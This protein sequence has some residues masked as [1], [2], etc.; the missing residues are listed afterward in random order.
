[1][2]AKDPSEANSF[3]DRLRSPI[4]MT[5]IRS[6]ATIAIGLVLTV[7]LPTRFTEE[8][9]AQ[10]MA[11]MVAPFEG[12]F[13]E[14]ARHHLLSKPDERPKIAIVTI[15]QESLGPPPNG[16]G[17]GSWPAPYR[18]YSALL[19]AL[20]KA[21]A[22]AVFLDV[23]LSHA[24]QR[25]EFDTLKTSI[26]AF[27]AESRASAEHPHVFLAARRDCNNAL[28][29]NPDIDPLTSVTKVG[30]EFSPNEVDR[31]AWTYPLAYM[32]SFAKEHEDQ[33]GQT[34][35]PVSTD[36]GSDSKA[37][38]NCTAE[39][40]QSENELPRSAA[41]A[42]YLALPHAKPLDLKD[43]KARTMSV[44]WGL[45]TASDGL[46]WREENDE[47]KHARSE[48]AL[49]H[50]DA[51]EPDDDMYCTSSDHMPVLLLRAEA[52]AWYRSLSRPLC[53]FH[54]TYPASIILPMNPTD[55]AKLLDDR[56]VL[57]GTSLRYSNDIVTSPL[58]DRIPGVFLHAMAL[59]NLIQ[60]HGEPPKNWEP[61]SSLVEGWHN[62]YLKLAVLGVISIFL[63]R[64]AKDA[65]RKHTRSTYLGRHE[66]REKLF[67]RQWAVAK[68]K[69]AAFNFLWYFISGLILIVFAIVFLLIGRHGMGLPYLIV[70]H[71]IAC[72]LAVEWLEW[73]EKFADWLMDW[74]EEKKHENPAT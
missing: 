18:Y 70:A 27:N 36:T 7:L 14:L 16:F 60:Y 69:V 66:R 29:I 42:M 37:K 10:R 61:S 59:D 41:A 21:G 54:P 71:L 24:Q 49:W 11:K 15:D 55:S 22:K 56:I 44:T 31:I 74:H 1:M 12:Y 28:K 45:D 30:I 48:S 25:A 57:V 33:A 4:G 47:E 50:I 35:P 9:G 39:H 65:V 64:A 62:G 20:R 26:D 58:H 6:I 73:G 5:I 46:P 51:R 23:V 67:S 13:Y 63:I 43:E 19:D 72:S 2:P 17:D 3:R 68:L 32:P 53:V 40:N 34:E 52:R 8:I 38:G